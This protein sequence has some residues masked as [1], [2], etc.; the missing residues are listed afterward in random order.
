MWILINGVFFYLNCLH[1][2]HPINDNNV[3]F[4]A[5]SQDIVLEYN[6]VRSVENAFVLRVKAIEQQLIREV[7]VLKVF[8]DFTLSKN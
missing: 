7:N 3:Y 1:F 4:F 5:V 6:S 8:S 2:G